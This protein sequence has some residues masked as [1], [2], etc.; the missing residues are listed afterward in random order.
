MEVLDEEPRKIRTSKLQGLRSNLDRDGEHT[1]EFYRAVTT[2]RRT[3][4]QI[5]DAAGA[6][7]SGGQSWCA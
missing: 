6:E 4:G 3:G 2:V 5:E 1:L 7:V